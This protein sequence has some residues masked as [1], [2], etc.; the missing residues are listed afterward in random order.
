MPDPS[1][2]EGFLPLT[3][4]AFEILL[5]IAEGPRHGYEVMQEIERRTSGRVRPNPG[6]LYRALDRLLTQGL[7][8]SREGEGGGEPS[9]YFRLSALGR[10]VAA[11][12]AHRLY[13]QVDAAVARGLL[14]E[15]WTP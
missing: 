7:L 13:E 5:A 2:A 3:P 6:T 4:M 14:P 9:R 12:E 15:G 11:A 10:R 1:R 8:E